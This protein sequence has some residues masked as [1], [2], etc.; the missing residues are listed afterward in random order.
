MSPLQSSSTSIDL[1]ARNYFDIAAGSYYLLFFGFP[2]R[3]NGVVT[4][5]CINPINGYSYGDAYY[6]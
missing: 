4:N 1:I 3:R 2:L 5:G 6:H